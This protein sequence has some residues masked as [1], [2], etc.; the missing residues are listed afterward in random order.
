LDV[1]ER[2]SV[3]ITYLGYGGR[4][5]RRRQE[6]PEPEAGSRRGWEMGAEEEARERERVRV[7]PVWKF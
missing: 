2:D 5:A 6:A 4:Q 3:R 1:T 7:L